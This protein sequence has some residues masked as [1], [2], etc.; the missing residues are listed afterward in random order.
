MFQ[1]AAIIDFEHFF[2]I[3]TPGAEPWLLP[4]LAASI[5][6]WHGFFLQSALGTNSGPFVVVGNPSEKLL[7]IFSMLQFIGNVK[8][9]IICINLLL[10]WSKIIMSYIYWMPQTDLL[11]NK[12]NQEDR[13]EWEG[14]T[15]WG[16][17]PCGQYWSA[18]AVQ[19]DQA[20]TIATTVDIT[21]GI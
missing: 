6:K 17:Q 11:D 16:W 3:S 5:H 9:I 10:A 2:A 20:T 19:G 12:N 4:A 7:L 14:T 8:Y 21:T 1:Y 13:I 15:E 18:K